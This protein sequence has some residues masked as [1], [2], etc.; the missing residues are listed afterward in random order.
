M[1]FCPGTKRYGAATG[2]R[3]RRDGAATAVRRRGR[4]GRRGGGGGGGC[5]S[6]MLLGCAWSIV[7]VQSARVHINELG[8]SA[9]E[10]T[11]RGMAFLVGRVITRRWYKCTI[12]CTPSQWSG[13]RGHWF[14]CVFLA[15]DTFGGFVDLH[16]WSGVYVLRD[17]CFSRRGSTHLIFEQVISACHA[18]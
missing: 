13:R 12:T 3:G 14:D 5:S 11:D 9:N 10:H 17:L 16:G 1:R 15:S 4:R 6:P 7:G 8:K 2:R 18:G